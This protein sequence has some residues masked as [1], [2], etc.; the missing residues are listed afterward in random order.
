M[1]LLGVCAEV[2]SLVQLTHLV[3]S[4]L[5]EG[6]A[7]ACHNN[8]L[9]NP[10]CSSSLQPLKNQ[11]ATQ[12]K[13]SPITHRMSVFRSQIALS[14]IAFHLY[15]F[16]WVSTDITSFLTQLMGSQCGPCSPAPSPCPL[17]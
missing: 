15:L 14:Y 13:P 6:L 4:G 8:A 10:L 17:V 3:L 16:A 2:S 5:D 1:K 9:P 12:I 11:M 7:S